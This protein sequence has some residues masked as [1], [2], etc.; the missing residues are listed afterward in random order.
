MSESISMCVEE[1]KR[2]K[3][4]NPDFVRDVIDGPKLKKNKDNGKSKNKADMVFDV[5]KASTSGTKHTPKCHHF[6]KRGYV[7]KDCKNFNDWLVK[8]GND[9]NSIIFES[10]LIDIPLNM[11]W[12]DTSSFVHI[13]NSLQ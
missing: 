5:N 1:E 9:F 10:L 11:W 4:E 12:I 3:A 2:I 13:T 8:K 6:K 7:R